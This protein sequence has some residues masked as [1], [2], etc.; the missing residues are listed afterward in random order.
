MENAILRSLVSSIENNILSILV[1]GFV[2][3]CVASWKLGRWALHVD[4]G[5]QQTQDSATWLQKIHDLID[6]YLKNPVKLPGSPVSLTERGRKIIEML[7]PQ[8]ITEAFALELQ[9]KTIG[10]GPYQ[11]QELA[12]RFAAQDMKERIRHQ[13][14]HRI[15]DIENTAFQH[16]VTVDQV[17]DALGVVLRDRLLELNNQS[18]T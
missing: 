18:N 6:T 4:T 17:L 7:K 1:V 9:P 8:D 15:S 13:F 2:I 12:F 11:I 3:G 14:P 10:N 16:G 5:L